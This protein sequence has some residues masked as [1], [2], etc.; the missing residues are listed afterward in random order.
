MKILVLDDDND[1]REMIC[2]MLTHEG[3]EVASAPDG[4]RGSK[5]METFNPDLII[6]DILMP[7]QDGYEII[8]K[9]NKEKPHV[10][11]IAISG[12]GS[13]KPKGYLEIAGK[14]G[15]KRTLV[16]P[17]SRDELVLAIDGVF[18]EKKES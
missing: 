12:G 18:R 10:K 9:M 6:T 17:F 7:D 13:L 4:R 14:L 16:K 8:M 11:V 3:H 5:V 1:F 15:A 2:E